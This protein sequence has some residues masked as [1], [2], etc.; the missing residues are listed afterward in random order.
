MNGHIGL[1]ELLFENPK[2]KHRD[3]LEW[4]VCGNDAIIKVKLEVLK[5]LKAKGVNDLSEIKSF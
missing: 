5:F 4:K 3:D 1:F 2:G